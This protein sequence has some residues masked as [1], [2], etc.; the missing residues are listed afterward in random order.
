MK[1]LYKIL[2]GNTMRMKDLID[3]VDGS[4]FDTVFIED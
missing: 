4:S 2:K 3:F 1:H